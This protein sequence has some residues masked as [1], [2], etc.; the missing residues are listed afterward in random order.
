[1]QRAQII[2]LTKLCEEQRRTIK[3][4][5][6]SIEQQVKEIE[7]LREDIYMCERGM[8]DVAH[9]IRE[10]GKWCHGCRHYHNDAYPGLNCRDCGIWFCEE[11]F[12]ISRRCHIFEGE[13]IYPRHTRFD[14]LVHFEGIVCCDCVRKETLS[15]DDGWEKR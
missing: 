11:C 9:F 8:D 5:A 10:A 15:V 6:Q 2:A 13:T 1:M 14:Q 4:Q 3:Q 7:E 12:E